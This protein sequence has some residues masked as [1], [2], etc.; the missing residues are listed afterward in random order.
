M[1]MR[2]DASITRLSDAELSETILQLASDERAATVRLVAH[3][4]EFDRR[5]LHL[6]LGFPSLFVYCCEVLR[7]ADHETS[8]RIEVARAAQRFPAILEMLGAGQV[9]LTT[10]RLLA[11][12][13]SDENHQQLLGAASGRSKRDVEEL[14]ARRAPRP[15]VPAS[16]RKVPERRHQ[17]APTLP[18]SKPAA[19]AAPPARRPS[20]VPLPPW[21]HEGR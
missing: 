5:R 11:P 14:L 2:I 1:C 12:H 10:A 8:N 18:E 15:D 7:L 17:E 4:A 6:G 9:S 13:L 3:L 19:P 16:V 21:R 20:V